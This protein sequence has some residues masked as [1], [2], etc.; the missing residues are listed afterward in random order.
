MSHLLRKKIPLEFVE[1]SQLHPRHLSKQKEDDFQKYL[2]DAFRGIPKEL[3]ECSLQSTEKNLLDLF[4]ELY[5]KKKDQ[6]CVD[7]ITKVLEDITENFIIQHIHPQTH[8]LEMEN[9]EARILM[10]NIPHAIIETAFQDLIKQNIAFPFKKFFETPLKE[11]FSNLRKYKPTI[12]NKPYRLSNCRMTNDS[13]FPPLFDGEYVLLLNLPSN[14]RRIDL[15]ADYFTEEQRLKSI[16]SVEKISPMEYWNTYFMRLF[17]EVIES[18]Q[19]ISARTMREELYH[20]VKE[21]TQ[22]KPTVAFTIY[23]ILNSKKILDFSAGWGD[24]LIAAIAAG[25]KTYLGFDP[26]IELKQG[27]SEIIRTFLNKGESSKEFRVIYEPFETA[28]IPEGYTFDLCFTSPPYFNLEIYSNQPNQSIE[29]YPDFKQWMRKFLFASLEK[30]WNSLDLNGH[31][32]IHIADFGKYRIA[33]PMNL[34][35]QYYLHG[36]TY[37]GVIG[38]EGESGKILP[39]WIWKKTSTTDNILREKVEERMKVY[40]DLF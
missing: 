17:E 36:A 23:N 39:I 3:N 37:R 15:I 30:A 16:R 12:S 38:T 6:K 11:L 21:C 10:R 25:A 22:F 31:L 32:A 8:L 40:K 13:L 29:R 26:N 18:G 9:D 20:Q 33:E 35:I 7:K 1:K 14:Y 19:D 24:R 34:F 5:A 28:E 27:H 4:N 2:E